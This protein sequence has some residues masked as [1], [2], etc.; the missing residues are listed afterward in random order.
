ME[1]RA[2][3]PVSAFRRPQSAR[4]R[5]PSARARKQ[6]NQ[7]AEESPYWLFCTNYAL[8]TTDINAAGFT[9]VTLIDGARWV[10]DEEATGST[11]ETYAATDLSYTFGFPETSA[12]ESVTLD[13]RETLVQNIARTLCAS[14][15]GGDLLIIFQNVSQAKGSDIPASAQALIQD[16]AARIIDCINTAYSREEAAL[17]PDLAGVSVVLEEF[18]Q[19]RSSTLSGVWDDGTGIEFE[20]QPF[21]DA[22]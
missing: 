8:T 16:V 3:R 1:S 2:A 13:H 22:L 7:D 5:P 19:G 11:A 18:G 6:A 20:I 4:V 9:N 12:V 17:N 21:S 14:C 10:P 15:R